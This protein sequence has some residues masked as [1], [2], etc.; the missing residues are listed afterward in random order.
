MSPHPNLEE[1]HIFMKGLRLARPI[2]VLVATAVLGAGTLL[3][4]TGTAAARP[5]ISPGAATLP[6][7][8]LVPAPPAGASG[9]DD[10]TNFATPGVDGGLPVIWTEYQNGVNPDGTPGPG[11]ATNSTVAGYDATTGALVKTFTLA[12]HVDGLTGDPL[13]HVL[14]ATTN[15]DANSSMFL[16]DPSAGTVVNYAYSPD[17]ATAGVGGTDSI[18]VI[19]S[20]IYVTHSNPKDT[21]QAADYSVT[22]DS[23]THTARLTS[24][25]FDNSTA[26]DAVTGTSTTLA[27]T[28]PDSNLPMPATEPRFGGQLATVSQA[29]GQIIFSANNTGVPRLTVLNLT[30]NKSGNTPPIDGLAVATTNKGTLFVVDASGNKIQALD[31]TG[32]PAGT[33][34]VGE[35]SD[36]SNPLVGTLDLTTGKIT[37]FT[38]TFGSPKGILFVPA[39]GYE[40]TA[41]DGGVFNF[42]ATPFLGSTGAKPLNKPIVGTAAT[43]DGGGYWQVASDGGIFAFGD[44]SFLGSMGGT[45][46]NQP[47]VGMAATPDG[48]G[49]WLVAADGGIFSFGTAKFFGSM[50]GNRLNRPIVGIAATPDGGGYWMVASDGGI[51]SFGDASFLGS[52][53]GTPLNRP[54]VGMASTPYGGGYWMVA[55]DGGIFSFGAPFLG[56]MGGTRLNRPIVGMAST[57][58]GGGYWMVASDGGIFSFGAPFLGSMG[59][60]RLNQPI[61][62]MAA[63]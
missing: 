42:G 19:G 51:F 28:D 35:P 58:D 3:A 62:G 15:E 57:P 20:Q 13:L 24:S 46:L 34:F 55:S 43:P 9:P 47:I 14:I 37:P 56:S 17:P 53:G 45:S 60:T 48:K 1:R 54:I 4:S 59:G 49:Y 30:D 27:L 63:I 36:N 5:A 11:G 31:T 41:A 32:W 21:T 33:V 40:L 25:F 26:T 16:I 8:T 6:S 29:D 22:L 12:G 18:A 38:N 10:I 50:G 52:M 23:T 61:V 7:T 2:V 39:N 44:A